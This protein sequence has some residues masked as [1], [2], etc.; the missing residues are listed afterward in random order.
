MRAWI[1]SALHEAGLPSTCV[2]DPDLKIPVQA[3]H[4]LLEDSVALSGQDAFGLLMAE[5]R[6]LSNLGILGMLLREESTLRLALQS[7]HSYGGV[8]NEALQQRI[9]ES[10]G[11]ATIHEELLLGSA[12]PCRQANE[13]LVAVVL[14]IMHFF[15]GADWKA[16]RI[17]FT[18]TA[19]ADA[20]VHR[21]VLGQS[22]EFGCD[23]NGI[24]CTSA[25]LDTPIASADPV[26]ASYFRREVQHKSNAAMTVTD[27]VRQ[28]VLA[29]MPLGR[30]TVDQVA[31]LMG[32]TRRTLYRHLANE[33]Q[34]FTELLQSI[35][36]ELASRYVNEPQH[37]LTAITQLLGFTDLSSFSRWHKTSFGCSAGELR[38]RLPPPRQHVRA[39]KR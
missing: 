30:C 31:G 25:D 24:V 19:P 20:S 5:G 4:R 33:G 36:R 28:M 14:K 9:D 34:V 35:R 27:E 3:V 7:L 10:E 21:R 16:R 37:S 11:I 39:G 2:N 22:P 23:F 38:K 8:Q 6:R 1:R 13:L 26:V 29:L 15:L 12:G 18:H 17:C 32:I